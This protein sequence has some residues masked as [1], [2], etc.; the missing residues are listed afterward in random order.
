[1]KTN[2][3]TYRLRLW[4]ALVLYDYLCERG[5]VYGIPDRTLGM[6]LGQLAAAKGNNI[7]RRVFKH[8][9]TI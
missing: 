8:F 6:L 7:V 2:S 4:F 1:M 5:K 3:S 9:F